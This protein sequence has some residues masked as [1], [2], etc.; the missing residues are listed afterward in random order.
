MI[1]TREKPP[2]FFDLQSMLMVEENHVRGSRTTLSSMEEEVDQHA[3]MAVDKSGKEDT[4]KAGGVKP[5]PKTG[6]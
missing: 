5:A 6:K 4:P 1:C 3:R 2:S